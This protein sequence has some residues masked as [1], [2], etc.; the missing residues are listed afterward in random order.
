MK[1]R[2]AEVS[3]LTKICGVSIEYTQAD[4]LLGNLGPRG[5]DEP[6]EITALKDGP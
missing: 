1:I 3:L 6:Y 4:E 2:S 5:N